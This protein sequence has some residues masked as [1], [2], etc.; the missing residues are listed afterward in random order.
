MNLRLP[1]TTDVSNGIFTIRLDCHGS[2]FRW[3]DCFLHI[4]LGTEGESYV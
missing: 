2:S 4:V 3:A 1:V